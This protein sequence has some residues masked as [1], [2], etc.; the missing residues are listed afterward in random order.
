EGKNLAGAFHQPAV[1]LCDPELLNTL[2]PEEIA[3]GIRLPEEEHL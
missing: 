2:P 1:V 3:S